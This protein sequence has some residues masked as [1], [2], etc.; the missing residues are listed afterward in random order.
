MRNVQDVFVK[1]LLQEAL[2]PVDAVQLQ[3]P[4]A[5]HDEQYSDVFCKPLPDRPL[6]ELVPHLGLV[7]DMTVNLC[8][9]EPCSTTITVAMLRELARKQL[10]LYHQ[11]CKDA[12]DRTQSLPVPPQWVISPGLPV[13][14]LAVLPAPRAEG[15][16][17]GFYRSSE[18]LNVWLVVLPEL[19]KTAETRLLR[20]MGPAE[21]R[22][23]VML[24]ISGLPVAD[25]AR[26]PWVEI[27][28]KL[29]YF[30][31]KKSNVA[32]EE[33]SDMTQ[34]TQEFEQFK[35]EL[36]REAAARGKA[37]M[38]LAVL[39]A[40]GVVPSDIVRQKIL[41]CTDLLKLDRWAADAATAASPA[42][43][44]TAAA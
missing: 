15:W 35:S 31:V 44:L 3:K 40:R 16:P 2:E 8:T 5:P 22:Q 37:E 27:V 32:S 25:P 41:A 1:K 42:D 36:R 38:L 21:M 28:E 4:I 39:A 18:L 14:V 13:S 43:V 30:L 33:P 11:L 24:E 19:P 23:A 29:V 6:R 20:L 17:A 9:I 12:G 7:W 26:Q 10:S 34:L